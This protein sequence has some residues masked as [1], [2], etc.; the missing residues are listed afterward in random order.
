VRHLSHRAELLE[1]DVSTKYLALSALSA[2][3]ETVEESER[4][5]FVKGTLSM[6]FVPVDGMMLLDP[7]T[8]ANLEILRNLRTGDPR[9]SLF[10][11]LN[12]CLTAAGTRH[13]RS[14]L[15][16]PSTDLA[17]ISARLD[18]VSELLAREE[19]L[20]DA[21]RVLPAFADS[22]RLL[23]HFMQKQTQTGCA[24]AKAA[25]T[26]ILQLKSV[27]RTA[28]VLAAALSASGTDPPHNALLLKICENLST[29]E[30]AE[31]E[32]HIDAI[33]ADDAAYSKR[34]SQRMLECLFAIKPKVCSFLDVTRQ[35]LSES[36]RDMEHLVSR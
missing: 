7:S 3:I 1:A 4:T 26:A 20:H 13:L 24:R 25:I 29:P 11:A 18:G 36:T 15:I 12:H 19:A 23:K 6:S 2:L 8:I 10:G 14:S 27:L 32:A 28:P 30:V 5:Q 22:E 31:V 34:T 17:T 9:H 16:Q 33:V 35:T 21:R